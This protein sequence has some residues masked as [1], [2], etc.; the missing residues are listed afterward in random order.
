MEYY[1]NIKNNKITTFLEK[2]MELQIIM[3]SEI[4]QNQIVKCHIISYVESK[5]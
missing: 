1:S 4:S 3:L 2:Y 5:M